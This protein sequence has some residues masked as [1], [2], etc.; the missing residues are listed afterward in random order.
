MIKRVLMAAVMFTALPV[1]VAAR[2]APVAARPAPEPLVPINQ[3]Y[4]GEMSC[5]YWVGIRGQEVGSIPKAVTVNWILGYLTAVSIATN[6][7]LLES[8]DQASVAAWMDNYC[9]AHPL[10]NIP[11]ATRALAAE[12]R[13]RLGY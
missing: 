10:E 2:P 9:L 6:R 5:G 12:L 13:A 7:N 3:K 4:M 11:N 8:V 1:S